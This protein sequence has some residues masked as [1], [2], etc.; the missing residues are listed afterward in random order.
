V[1]DVLSPLF[2]KKYAEEAL[3]SFKAF[4]EKSE[5]EKDNNLIDKKGLK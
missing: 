4:K 2:E 5:K 3:A 1:F